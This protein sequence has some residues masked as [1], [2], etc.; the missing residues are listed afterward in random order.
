M[1]DEELIRAVV[2]LIEQIRI[3]DFRDKLGHSIEMNAA[4]QDLVLELTVR[5]LLGRSR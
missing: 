4:F 5:G 3:C 2:L 1:N